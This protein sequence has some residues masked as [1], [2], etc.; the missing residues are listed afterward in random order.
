M[1]DFSSVGRMSLNVF[2][3]GILERDYLFVQLR[4]LLLATVSSFFLMIVVIVCWFHLLQVRSPGENRIS[5]DCS[6][7]VV[8]SQLAGK[9]LEE[10]PDFWTNLFLVTLSVNWNLA[11]FDFGCCGVCFDFAF[12]YRNSVLGVQSEILMTLTPS[13]ILELKWNLLLC[14][15]FALKW[16]LV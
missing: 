3:L 5:T 9:K 11:S 4:P 12:V 10:E 15:I 8:A 16:Y 7:S 13:G 1:V 14:H 6:E 2:W